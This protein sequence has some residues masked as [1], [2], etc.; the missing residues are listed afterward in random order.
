MDWESCLEKAIEYIE[1]NLENELDV[2]AV[3]RAAAVSPAYLQKGFSVMT[4]Y[5]VGEY[6]R[7]RRLYEAALTLT[8]GGK[9]IDAALRFGYD[10]PE[11]FTKAFVR[12]HGATP[13][14]VRQDSR[15]IRRFVPVSIHIEL[16]GGNRM[17]VV[18]VPMWSFRVIGFERT[19][20][21]GEGYEKIPKFWDELCEKYCAGIYAGMPPANPYEKAVID[22]CI[23]EYAVCL[24]EPDGTCF[25]YL[26]GGRYAGGEVPEGMKV[27]ELPGGMWAKFR[28]VGA[29]PGAFQSLNTQ[30]FREWLPQNGEWE[31]SAPMNVEWYSCDR[32][33]DDPAYESGVWIPVKPKK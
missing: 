32:E 13:A 4:G 16:S 17:D 20:S 33:K 12:F 28:C 27:V 29:I 1:Q 26:V 31:Q 14:A 5:S 10:T 23:G 7:N 21:A 9:V 2:E 8:E 6:I 15:L 25:R 3:A 11:S 18:V 24:D 22:N 30:V 19:F